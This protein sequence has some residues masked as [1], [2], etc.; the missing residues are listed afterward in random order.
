MDEAKIQAQRRNNDE[1]STERRAA[2]LGLQYL[3][4]RQ[5]EQALPLVEGLLSID[6]MHK[7][8]IIPLVMGSESE[9]Y[10]FAVTSTTPQSLLVRMEREYAD[11]GKAIQFFL[12]SQSG[13]D[14]FMLRY[15]PP[16]EIHYDDIEIAKE[17]DSETIASV[18]KTLNSVGTDMVFDYLVQQ[19]DKLGASDIHIENQRSEIRVRM[20][21]D[22]AL[23]SVAI[24]EKDRYRVLMAALSSQANI[25]TASRAPQSGHMHKEIYDPSTNAT[26]LLNLRVEAVPTMYGQDVVLR[27]FN[28]NTDDLN[29]DLLGIAPRERK[30]IDEVVSHPRGMLL[31]VGPTG[32]GK[33]TT[34]YSIL[35][36]LNTDDRKIITL[37]DPIENSIPG[38][39]QIPIDTTN[40]QYFADGLRSVLRLDP[41]V[42]MVGEIR[43]QETARTA[44]QASITGHLV[45]SSFHANST[46]AAFSRIIDMIGQNPIFSSSIRLLIAQRLV[47]RLW[48]DSKEEFRPDE[49]TRRWVKEVLKDLPPEIE[50]PDLDTFKLWRAVPTDDVPFGYKGRMPVMEQMVVTE[51]VQ[52]F[53]RGDVQDIHTETIEAAA[54][55]QG[56]VTL[57]QAGVLA[58]LRGETTLEEVNRVI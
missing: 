21:V 9:P 55:K 7:D 36:A 51:E 45:L 11:D 5:I 15:D 30:E 53:I 18:S 17:G 10:R 4:T 41:D 1:E 28:F 52:K 22:G 25:S 50:H 12:I 46:S 48:Q 31:M 34:L 26:H 2:I 56:M 49:A 37:E 43:D 38:V 13:Y 40:G 3:D 29:L 47:R 35:N 24:L 20:R 8:R 19:A 32:S 16:P 39:T 54:K 33:S 27:L 6:Q 14:A 57:L 58:A 42:V 23:H 44:I